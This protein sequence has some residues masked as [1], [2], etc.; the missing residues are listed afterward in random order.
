[1]A[2][3]LG[4]SNENAADPVLT[5]IERAMRSR[6]DIDAG[7]IDA[8]MSVPR[9]EFVATRDRGKANVD[10]ALSI[11]KG[12]TISQ[13]SLVAHM[14]SEL[15]L[16]IN[17]QRVLDV[18]CGSGYQAAILSKLAEKVISVERI[19]DLANAARAR[20]SRL[21]YENIEVMMASEDVLG[22]PTEAPYDAIIVG[23]SVPR[24][25]PSLV[26]QMKLG[27]R[28]VIPVGPIGQQR[29]ATVTR[30]QDDFDV[31]YGVSCVFVPLIG[32]EA[33]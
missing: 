24:V 22:R 2:R 33:W 3:I 11:G 17:A 5:D 12:Q 9:Q 6:R 25:P 1:M 13:P 28:M 29:V 19:A 16:P 15:R 7:V 30:Q 23:A 26:S 14:I 4:P 31:C 21:G 10:R 18:G 8:V 32:P 20:L 27:S